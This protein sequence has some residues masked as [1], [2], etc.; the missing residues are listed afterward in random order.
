VC[1]L[2][3]LAIE[4]TRRIRKKE[5]ELSKAIRL[6]DEIRLRRSAHW[7]L[8]GFFLFPLSTLACF[9]VHC[10]ALRIVVITCDTSQLA[11]YLV[12]IYL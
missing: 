3:W 10:T 12:H 7:A 8:A 2:K 4:K 5:K 1:T 9:G 6:V 11:Y